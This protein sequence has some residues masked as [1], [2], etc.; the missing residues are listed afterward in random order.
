MIN[1]HERMLPTSAGVEPTTSWSPVGRRIQLSHQGRIIKEKYFKLDFQD[2]CHG[3]HLGFPIGMTLA[4]FCLQV[5]PI[6]PN[7]FQVSWPFISGEV[8]NMFSRCQPKRPSCIS[9]KNDFSYFLSTI[10]PDTSYQVLS[11]L[12]FRFKRRRAN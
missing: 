8:Q 12:A 1:L 7:K 4:I 6:F 11:Q 3:G 5:T 9:D 10:C 2:G